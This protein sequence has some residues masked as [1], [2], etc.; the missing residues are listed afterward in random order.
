[1]FVVLIPL[2]D[3]NMAVCAY[4]MFTKKE[5]CFLNPS[6]M[7]TGMNDG[8][9]R[10]EGLDIINKIGIDT[11]SKDKIIF[12][13][14]NKIS[15]FTDLS[16]ESTL[17]KQRIALLIDDTI[18]P[19][20]MNIARLKE[21]KDMGFKLGIRKLTVN[22]FEDYREIL[23]IMDY[24]MFD[25]HKIAIDKAKIYFG[26]LYPDIKL[27]A[28]NINTNER[29]EELK[30][31]GGYDLY[32]GGFYRI[33]VT[34]GEN[35]VS[36]LKANYVQLMNIVNENN[37]DLTKAA[38]V[39]G[40]DTAL[41]IS[42]LKIVNRMAFN[43][44]I[45]TIRYAAAMLGQKELRRWVDTAVVRS[46]YAEKPNEITRLSLIRAKFA[47]NLAELFGMK[48]YAAELFLMGLFSVID[49]IMEQPMVEALETVKL[50][51]NIRDALIYHNGKFT[52][53]LE[54]M[55]NYERA[56]WNEV[57]RM[58][59]LQK[60]EMDPIFDAYLGALEWYKELIRD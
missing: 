20:E 37:F 28:G 45:T 30:S 36:P 4:S 13:P 39:I 23:K 2:F 3:E 12:V 33:P 6:T 8:I 22:K 50:S 15:M 43:S 14:V 46:M 41:T 29:F 49:I 55:S 10:I 60:M 18:I 24:I 17:P 5:N 51:E 40:Q 21:L 32:E 34:K 7:G 47:E 44:E 35:K 1:M 11:L 52:P 9:S 42:L 56:N 54:F 16:D 53:V 38:D 48:S 27:C 57:S 19:S 26:K 58:M 59:I 31:D 25:E